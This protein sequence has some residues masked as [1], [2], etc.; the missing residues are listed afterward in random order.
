[1]FIFSQV[2]CHLAKKSEE[3]LRKIYRKMKCNFKS[4]VCQL[5]F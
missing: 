5:R 3:V 1:M 4:N 2:I